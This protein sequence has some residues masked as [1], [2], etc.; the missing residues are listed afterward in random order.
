MVVDLSSR[1]L[2][3]SWLRDRSRQCSKLARPGEKNC[4]SHTFVQFSPPSLLTTRGKTQQVEGSSSEYEESEESEEEEARFTNEEYDEDDAASDKEAVQRTAAAATGVTER[5]SPNMPTTIHRRKAHP[6]N[7]AGTMGK[8][9]VVVSK[10]NNK[11]PAGT[12]MTRQPN[13]Q[14]KIQLRLG[15]NVTNALATLRQAIDLR[16]SRMADAAKD[17]DSL[18]QT[19][20]RV[21]L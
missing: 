21:G 16:A 8:A 20:S 3:Q 10:A 2:C 15:K 19:L 5:A 1:I 12:T 18:T 17:L 7:V 13:D 14:D 11:A 6:R 9:V 4:A